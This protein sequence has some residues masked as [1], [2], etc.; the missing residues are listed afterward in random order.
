M[1]RAS[2]TYDGRMESAKPTSNQST[3]A[4]ASHVQD[5]AA[6]YERAKPSKESHHGNLDSDKTTPELEPDRIADA[7][8]NRQDPTHQINAEDQT[9]A[10]MKSK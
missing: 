2:L 6:S 4:K 3:P 9:N 10:R 1:N 7:V 5:P 8:P